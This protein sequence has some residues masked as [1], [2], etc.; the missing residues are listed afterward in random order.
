MKI[1]QKR[2]EWLQ[3][4]CIENIKKLLNSPDTWEIGNKF[5]DEL[6]NY[7]AQ[8]ISEMDTSEIIGLSD[9][10]DDEESNAD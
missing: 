3:T 8:K 4:A 2:L 1:P 6:I 7:R 10:E 5:I 9:D